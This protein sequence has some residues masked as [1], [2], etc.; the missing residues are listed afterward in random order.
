MADADRN[1]PYD[2]PS[3]AKM[4]LTFAPDSGTTAVAWLSHSRGG[5]ELFHHAL[6]RAYF[7]ERLNGQGHYAIQ[8]MYC[9]VIQK[10]W[11]RQPGMRP[12]LRE[13]MAF[14]FPVQF[15]GFL[16]PAAVQ[17]QLTDH[18]DVSLANTPNPGRMMTIRY[19]LPGLAR[20]RLAIYD[21]G[22]RLVRTFVKPDVVCLAGTYTTKWDGRSDSGDRAAGGL[23]F[24]RLEVNGRT[25]VARKIILL[26]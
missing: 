4:Y 5:L 15:P 10:L 13:A 7:D 25:A 6:A 20:I 11:K 8:E 16:T 24:A 2:Y 21:V 23:Y 22:G 19:D 12:F 26:P 9:S 17:E 14:G 1:N 18:F 3:L